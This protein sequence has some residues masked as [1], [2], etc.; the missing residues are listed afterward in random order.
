MLSSY[1]LSNYTAKRSTSTIGKRWVCES[2]GLSSLCYFDK[3]PFPH[4]NFWPLIGRLTQPPLFAIMSRL[5]DLE[6][7][8]R[9]SFALQEV[10]NRFIISLERNLK[11]DKARLQPVRAAGT[12]SRVGAGNVH[13]NSGTGVLVG[14]DVADRE[15]TTI[16]NEFITSASSTDYTVPRTRT[17]VG[18]RAFSVAGPVVW[19]NLP[20]AVSEADSLQSLSASIQN[21]SVYCVF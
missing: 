14:S 17:K 2:V 16:V 1:H 3:P 7:R 6:C 15:P 5:Y 8:V 13:C 11:T 19:N 9:T 21:S 12:T 18:D 10:E 4:P 20:A